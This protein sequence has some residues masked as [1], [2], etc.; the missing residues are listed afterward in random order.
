MISEDQAK[1]YCYEI[2]NIENYSQAVNDKTQIWD[3][4]HRGEILS[5]GTYSRQDLKRFG[6]YWHRPAS[7]LIFLPHG[8][9]RRLHNDRMKISDE[10]KRKISESHKGEK[11]KFFG[12]H[13]SEEA[14][15]K[16]SEARKLYW[17]KRRN[18]I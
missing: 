1:R 13:H 10:T 4:H 6:L 2:E 9:H 8:K 16:I 5:C 11:N 3:C 7:E 17:E 18:L 12:K 15:R 14:R